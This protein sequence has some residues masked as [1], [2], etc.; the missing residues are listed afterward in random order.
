[1]R[2]RNIIPQYAV[3]FFRLFY[4]PLLPYPAVFRKFPVLRIH[5]QH[6]LDSSKDRTYIPLL[7]HRIPGLLPQPFKMP[8]YAI[9]HAVIDL[10]PQ[11]FT[12]IPGDLRL[13]IDHNSRHTLAYAVLQELCF[14]FI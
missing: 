4:K 7:L 14:L 2:I 6:K 8:C 1:M 5:L 3:P 12:V 13:F 10:L 9:F 11:F